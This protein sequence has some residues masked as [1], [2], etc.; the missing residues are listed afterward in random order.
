MSK[1]HIH[2]LLL[3]TLVLRE[4]PLGY[5]KDIFNQRKDVTFHRKE[6]SQQAHFLDLEIILHWKESC[7]PENE[8]IFS[9]HTF[10][11]KTI[12]MLLMTW[13]PDQHASSS[14]DVQRKPLVSA[15]KYTNNRFCHPP[16][17]FGLSFYILFKIQPTHL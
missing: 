5:R 15:F 2:Y 1:Q 4:V 6:L 12:F 8:D 11:I 7:V 10:S 14:E 17:L 16:G 9:R 3:V 13:S